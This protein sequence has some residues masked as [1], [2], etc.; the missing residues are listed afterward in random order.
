[1]C[2]PRVS[3]RSIHA[4]GG[5]HGVCVQPRALPEHEHLNARLCGSDG[6]AAAGRAGA[7]DEDV[8]RLGSMHGLMVHPTASAI[9]YG[10]LTKSVA[11]CTI[12]PW[13]WVLDDVPF[14]RRCFAPV[15][16]ALNGVQNDPIVGVEN[17]TVLDF[18]G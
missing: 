17:V 10:A 12:L 2:A 14:H 5:E 18:D 3:R 7:D 16:E 9:D 1:L 13:C 4:A 8:G 15:Q 6:G 11:S